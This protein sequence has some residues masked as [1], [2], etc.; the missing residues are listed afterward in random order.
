MRSVPLAALS[1]G[2]LLTLTA[3]PQAQTGLRTIEYV[4]GFSRPVYLTSPPGDTSREF[5]VEQRGKIKIIKDGNVLATPFLDVGNAGLGLLGSAGNEQGLLGLAFHPDYSS[6]GRFFI[7][8][9]DSGNDTVVA[10]F[11]VSAN[12][13]IANTTGTTIIGPIFQPQSNHNGGCLQFSPVDGMLYIGM[14]D[15]GGSNDSGSGHAPGG[16]AQSPTTLLGKMLR[17]DVDIPFPHIPADNPFTGAGDPVLDEVWATGVRNPWRFSFDRD[18]GDMHMADVGQF[19]WEE[20]NYEPAGMGGRNYGWRCMEGLN[21]TGLSGCTCNGPT[22]TL[23]VREYGH[24]GGNCSV[25]GGYVYRGCAIPDLQGTYFH[26]DYCSGR[27]WSYEIVGG[28]QTNLINRTSEL[29]PPTGSINQITSFGEDALGELYILD[30]GGEI[31]RILPDTIIDCNANLMPDGCDIA[32]GTSSDCNDNGVPDECETLTTNYCTAGTSA[33]GCVAA[34]T[35]TGVPSASAPT[36]FTVDTTSIE[37]SKD[38]IFFYGFNGPQANSWGSGT[39]FQCV[40]PPV[41]RTS[42]LTGSGTPGVCDGS[43][44]LD[45]NAFWTAAVPAKQ[46]AAGQQVNLQLWYR[47]PQNTSN[48]TTSLSDGLEFTVCP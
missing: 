40:T 23:P 10:E 11:T 24:N 27:I 29:A 1:V 44:S 39:S 18:N 14:G 7:N 5:V 46:P 13:D 35:S 26:A 30:Q 19:S 8:Y 42:L 15:G 34:L 33:S 12:P 17:L 43:F 38:G 28:V 22:L 31:Y 16:N 45:F 48:Q 2:T 3:A 41:I 9:T 6:N 20:L 36:G 37:G 47:D 32:L 4:N 21:C 25:T